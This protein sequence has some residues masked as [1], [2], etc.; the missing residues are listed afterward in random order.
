MAVLVAVAV[1][2]V[3]G[4]LGVPRYDDVYAAFHRVIA[5]NEQAFVAVNSAE[6]D[7]ARAQAIE[8]VALPAV[9]S[10][11]A[12]LAALEQVPGDARDKVEALRRYAD[13][14]HQAFEHELKGLR[15]KDPIELLEA[16]RLHE[17]ADRQP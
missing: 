7:E 14:T 6:G 16:K 15:T 12:E 4:A 1:L 9:E 5:L 11:Q 2:L 10:M 3:A 17:E 13:L 8:T